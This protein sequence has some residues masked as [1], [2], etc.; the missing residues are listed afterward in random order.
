MRDTPLFVVD[1]VRVVRETDLGWTCEIR[2]R[3]VFIGRL[4]V[5]SGSGVPP[6]GAPGRVTLTPAAARDLGL[7]DLASAAAGPKN[8]PPRC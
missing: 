6:V 8:S 4:Q 1:H 7:L 3:T 5:V 2:G